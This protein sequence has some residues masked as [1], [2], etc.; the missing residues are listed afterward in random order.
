MKKIPP[1]TKMFITSRSIVQITSYFDIIYKNTQ[2]IQKFIYF[3]VTPLDYYYWNAIGARMN[4]LDPQTTLREVFID[5]IKR[6]AGE[7][8]VDEIKKGVNSFTRRLR[9]IVSSLYE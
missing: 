9:N 7:I 3:Y 2:K 6:T 4:Y 8:P 1:A 5:E